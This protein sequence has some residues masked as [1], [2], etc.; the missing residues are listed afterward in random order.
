MRRSYQ[1]HAGAPRPLRA[2]YWLPLLAG[3]SASVHA[4]ELRLSQGVDYSQGKYGYDQA[5]RVWA[6]PVNVSWRQISGW[7]LE[8]SAAALRIDG[9]AILAG[10]S[11]P[12]PEGAPLPSRRLFASGDTTLGAHYYSPTLLARGIYLQGGLELKLPTASASKGVGTGRPD[13][14]AKL[15]LASMA[16]EIVV[17]FIDINATKV[18]RTHRY[19]LRDTYG[20][21]AG[22]S[23]RLHPEVTIGAMYD[24]RRSM[25][26]RSSQSAGAIGFVQ[27]KLTER[28]TVNIYGGTG[29]GRSSPDA[30]GGLQLNVGLE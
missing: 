17:P 15:R 23:I 9:P 3:F 10:G 7:T 18:G 4:G 19:D 1:P 28:A 27:T 13:L 8:A 14:T 25:F 11:A 26:R 16:S 2:I 29:F 12:P 5:T 22:A 20:A 30:R 6:V 24:W 21:A